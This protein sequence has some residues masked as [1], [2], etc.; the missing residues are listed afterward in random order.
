M[1][2]IIFILAL[3][4]IGLLTGCAGSGTG[5]K[6]KNTKEALQIE[7]LSFSN[8]THLKEG[9]DYVYEINMEIQWPTAGVSNMALEKIQRGITA[10]QFGEDNETTDINQAV[11]AYEKMRAD[12]YLEERKLVDK[13]EDW[14]FMLNWQEKVNGSFL[15]E[16][17]GMISYI[18]YRWEYFGGAYGNA[19]KTAMIFSLKSGD[20][21]TEED[22]FKPGYQPELT[23]VLRQNLA[24]TFDEQDLFWGI[25]DVDL[26]EC[27]YISS[28]GIT[29][30]YQTDEIS[31]SAVGIIEVT[32][33]WEDI[34]DILK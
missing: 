6:A 2:R 14:G 23:R 7:K 27:Y 33:P 26:S 15:P 3:S 28:E 12:I 34:K 1:K 25:E 24:R 29:Y 31:S 5:S 16:Y 10:L 19:E 17:N 11:D 18:N 21:I 4:S 20:I 9:S 13:L 30:I 32:I 8:S 22:L